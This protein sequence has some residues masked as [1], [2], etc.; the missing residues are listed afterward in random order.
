M[1]GSKKNN[2]KTRNT[3]KN[4]TTVNNNRNNSNNRNYGNTYG[5]NS[6]SQYGTGNRY[7]N[8]GKYRVSENVFS[9]GAG[10]NS[11]RGTYGSGRFS[12][13]SRT[14]NTRNQ[15]GYGYTNNTRNV[16]D[17]QERNYSKNTKNTRTKQH[18]KATPKL[19]RT[20]NYIP[21]INLSSRN[22]KAIPIYIF[23]FALVLVQVI[24]YS[25]SRVTKGKVNYDTVQYGTIDSPNV[26]QG[27]IVRD[28]KV[29]NTTVDGVISYDVADG[30]KVKPNTEV[31][32]IK[33]Q[34]A[35][36]SM[37]SDLEKI[38]N[39]IMD[40]QDKRDDISIYS[41]DINK[42]NQQ[43]KKIVDDSAI[44]FATLNLEDVYELKTNIEKELSER[45]QLLL[46][47]NQGALTDLVTK[48][49]AQEEKLNQ[50]IS[51]VS[52]NESGI[53]S[54][55]VIGDE[56]KYTL[57][58]M[59]SLTKKNT[60]ATTSSDSGFKTSVKANSP[61]FKIIKS[62]TWYIAA[63]ISEDYTKYWKTGNVVNIYAKDDNGVSYT[64]PATINT[65]STVKDGKEKYVILSITKN[66]LEFVGDRSI[67][68]E[69]QKSKK[70]YKVPNSSIV[71]ETLLQIPSDY[72]TENNTVNKVSGSNT[73]EIQVVVS[74]VDKEKKVSYVPVQLGILNVGDE[75]Q[76]PNSSNKY[77]IENVVNSNGIYVVNSGIAEFKI[78]SLD[79]S[80]SNSTHTILDI[81]KNPNINIYDRI[82]TDTEN[83]TKEEK[84]FE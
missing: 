55:D 19:K 53:V 78:V 77:K 42:D 48:R 36:A 32:S 18:K 28:E 64:L 52:T 70:G 2:K 75:I 83:V 5:R 14:N 61:V 39:D 13:S 47:E 67:S 20:R 7:S 60:L 40:V 3:K 38:D 37:E 54:Y 41:D 12:N 34:A 10:M 17:N 59:K 44:N 30:E 22:S 6:N 16:F 79:D 66:M 43:I 9:T 73:K 76:K 31:C 72:I 24:G 63:Y 68:F 46:S 51:K 25:V 21:I 1:F 15:N 82:M 81:G 50:S 58:T 84:V 8:V 57:E 62:S 74:S 4:N 80:V 65:L 29:Y 27:V 49:K 23:I 71:D 56:D 69:T 11:S 35:V 33:D 26:I 45:N